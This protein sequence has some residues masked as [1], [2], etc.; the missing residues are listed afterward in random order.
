MVGKRSSAPRARSALSSR[1]RNCYDNLIL[2]C[3]HHHTLID[4]ASNQYPV[5]RLQRFKAEHE[6]RIHQQRG[7][8]KRGQSTYL[9]DET[10][11]S[12][13]SLLWFRLVSRSLPR[14]STATSRLNRPCRSSPSLHSSPRTSWRPSLRCSWKARPFAKQSVGKAR[15]L[16]HPRYGPC[17]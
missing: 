10:D 2:L 3:R 9:D 12:P 6:A 16:L 4:K 15:P 5:E 7:K 8:G 17:P 13:W 1:Q 14:C 11:R